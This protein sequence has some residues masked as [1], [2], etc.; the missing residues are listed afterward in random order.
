MDSASNITIPR[1]E[2]ERLRDAER[3]LRNLAGLLLGRPDGLGFHHGGPW[4]AEDAPA[5]LFAVLRRYAGDSINPDG[6]PD[7]QP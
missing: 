3:D 7:A 4:I 1:T 6:G 5:S 2:Y